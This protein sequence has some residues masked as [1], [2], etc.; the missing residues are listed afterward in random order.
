MATKSPATPV[1]VELPIARELGAQARILTV[2]KTDVRIG[3]EAA[4]RPGVLDTLRAFDE[5]AID[6]TAQALLSRYA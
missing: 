4:S 5:K 2:K 6:E 3:W 1:P